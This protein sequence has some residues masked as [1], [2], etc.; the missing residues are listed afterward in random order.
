MKL[1]DLT[2]A[3]GE[4]NYLD[5]GQHTGKLDGIVIYSP[6][7]NAVAAVEVA[8]LPAA[9]AVAADFV[10]LHSLGSAI[11][12]PAGAATT[13]TQLAWESLRLTGTNGNV[14]YVTGQEHEHLR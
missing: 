12:L 2:I 1:P 7:T 10:D 6:S 3:A 13:I 11:T 9:D 8:H 14:F 4:S 5:R